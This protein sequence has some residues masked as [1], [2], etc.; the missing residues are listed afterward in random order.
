ME[1]K[2]EP[3][4]TSGSVTCVCVC[5]HALQFKVHFQGNFMSLIINSGVNMPTSQRE[6]DSYTAFKV[7][8][9]HLQKDMFSCRLLYIE[10]VVNCPDS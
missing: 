9:Q 4:I 2:E 6:P 7:R 3:R 5:S 10:G 1:K 8:A